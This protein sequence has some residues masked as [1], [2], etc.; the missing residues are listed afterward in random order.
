ML[1][2]EE[3]EGIY[4][5]RGITRGDYGMYS[6][7]PIASVA[8]AAPVAAIETAAAT[9]AVTSSA[10]TFDARLVNTET[11][12]SLVPVAQGFRVPFSIP[13]WAWVVLFAIAAVVLWRKFRG[14]K[15]PAKR[16]RR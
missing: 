1:S 6:T 11:N 13:K 9:T 3:V 16:G 5:G 8:V 2:R 7:P 14:S 10:P 15:Q 4:R 12:A